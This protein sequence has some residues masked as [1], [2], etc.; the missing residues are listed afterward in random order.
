MNEAMTI[1]PPRA[2]ICPAPDRN[3]LTLSRYCWSHAWMT[4]QAEW[5]EAQHIRDEQQD[6]LDPLKPKGKS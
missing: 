4:P 6:E 2:H 3:T 1:K 5:I